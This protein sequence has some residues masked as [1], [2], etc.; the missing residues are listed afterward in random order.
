MALGSVWAVAAAGLGMWQ[1][2]QP[3][4]SGESLRGIEAWQPAQLFSAWKPSWQPKQLAL[5]LARCMAVWRLTNL[6]SL[7]PCSVWHLPQASIEEWWQAR[8]VSL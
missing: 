8:Q 4:S 7:D 2:T 5:A 1:L 6:P 3:A